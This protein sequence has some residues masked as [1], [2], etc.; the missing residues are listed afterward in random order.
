MSK[1]KRCANIIA[2]ESE[3]ICKE[4]KLCPELSAMIASN[5]VLAQILARSEPFPRATANTLSIPS[6]ASIA[7]HVK[8]A[9]PS[10]QSRKRN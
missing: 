10:A 4:I 2:S 9:A 3:Y 5:A 7:V 6:N 8:K 1:S